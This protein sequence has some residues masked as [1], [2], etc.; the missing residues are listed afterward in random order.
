LYYIAAAVI[1]LGVFLTGVFK[2]EPASPC[3]QHFCVSVVQ[4]NI[5]PWDKVDPD[6]FDHNV[7][8][9]L[10]LTEESFKKDRPDLVIWPETAFPDDLLQSADWRPLIFKQALLMKAG[11]L[12]G[13]RPSSTERNTTAPY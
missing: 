5:L 9:H 11:L 13:Q 10:R 12:I 1:F 4:A 7:I 3:P 2:K 8:R 6:L